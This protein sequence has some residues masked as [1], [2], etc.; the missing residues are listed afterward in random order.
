V[1]GNSSM[2][3]DAVA[4]HAVRRR[5]ACGSTPKFKTPLVLLRHSAAH[6]LAELSKIVEKLIGDRLGLER[7]Q[8]YP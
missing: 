1:Q 6:N 2:S 8:E 3:A 7:P 4:F 5:R